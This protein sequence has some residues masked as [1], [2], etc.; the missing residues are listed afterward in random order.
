MQITQLRQADLN[1][2]VVF[3]VLAEERSISATAKRLYLSQ[4][5]VSRAFQRLQSMFN[6]KL[7]VRNKSGYELTTHGQRIIIEL[8]GLLPRIDQLL[9]GSAFDP[10]TE[11]ASFRI[12]GTDYACSV[13]GPALTRRVMAKDNK[14]SLEFHGWN[15]SVYQDIEHG[16]IDLAFHA[17]DGLFPSHFTREVLFEEDMV[18]VVAK[19]SPHKKKISLK[20]YAEANHVIVSLV[21]AEQSF[22]DIQLAALGIVRRSKLRLPYFSAAI[23]AIPGTDMIATV[24]KRFAINHR[25]NANII[26]IKPPAEING[27]NYLMVWHPRVNTDSTN[28]WLRKQIRAVSKA[29]S[30]K[31]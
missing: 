4:P 21:Q 16:R 29:I 7:L 13:L 6:D 9:R 2:L 30:G 15:P 1:L 12:S 11:A 8:E 19:N 18:C 20:N 31:K 27:Y 10:T 28:E 24:P 26:C 5:A 25:N 17:E 23:D 14:I 3:A 22:P